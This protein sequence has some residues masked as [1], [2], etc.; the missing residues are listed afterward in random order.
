[1]VLYILKK[2]RFPSNRN[3]YKEVAINKNN[4]F[5]FD[6]VWGNLFNLKRGNSKH[7]FYIHYFELS[8]SKKVEVQD[9]FKPFGFASCT[10]TTRKNK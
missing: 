10:S 1:M 2:T 4:K 9:V 6:Q 3:I 7:E 5:K 8:F